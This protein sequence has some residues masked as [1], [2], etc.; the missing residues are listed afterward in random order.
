MNESAQKYDIIVIGGGPTG[1]MA[2]GQAALLG[3][4]VLLLEKMQHPGLKLGITGKG[5]CNLTNQTN[6]DDFLRHFGKNGRFLK[7]A[8]HIF[9]VDQLRSFLSSIG[10]STKI[11]RGNRIFPDGVPAPRV[12]R[13]LKNWVIDTGVIIKT[14]S[15]VS[16]ILVNNGKT[17]GVK[18]AGSEIV[19]HANNVI[20]ATGG[21]S[22]PRTGSTGDG[23]IL[24]TEVGHRIIKPQ[25]S[26]V[27]FEIDAPF[28]AKIDGLTLKNVTASVCIDR[29]KTSQEF[30][31]MSF[32]DFG[33]TGPIILTLSKFLVDA[34]KHNKSIQLSI[35]LKPA[36]DHRQLD[37]R[38]LRDFHQFPNMS[39]YNILKK[40]LPSQLIPVCLQHTKIPAQ[41]PGSQITSE[42]RKHLRLWLKNF[43]FPVS[44]HRPIDEAIITSGGIDLREV[45]SKTMESR[46]IKNLYFA[47]EVLDIDA[48]TG[49]YNLQAAF[50]TGYLAGISAAIVPA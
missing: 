34:I 50:S 30:G 26:L 2:A 25:P 38:L 13:T 3:K 14:L 22:Y 46:I 45:H 20:L 11:E 33:V 24:A 9:F 6:L 12:S 19:I 16:K 21:K 40:L 35:D 47:G 32:T 1:M 36:L 10:I 42:E 43:H 7:P 44:G 39:F 15:P 48:D 18:L 27:P 17:E 23:Y 41:K 28:L 8:F 49:G 5:R 31:E 29:K 4:S 37:Q